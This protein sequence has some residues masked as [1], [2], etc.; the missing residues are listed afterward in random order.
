M[1]AIKSYQV[2]LYRWFKSFNVSIASERQQRQ[3]AS[4]KTGDNLVAEKG[5]F[6]FTTGKGQEIREVPFVYSPNLMRVIADLVE[7][8]DM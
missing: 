4:E 1:Y 2:S 3:L 8:N 7:K 5:A 6:T